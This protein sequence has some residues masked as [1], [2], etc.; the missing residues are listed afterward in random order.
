MVIRTRTNVYQTSYRLAFVTKYRTPM[1]TTETYRGTLK[2]L[3]YTAAEENEID[4]Q[5][6]EITED[7]VQLSVSFPPKYSISTVIKKL[8]GVSARR[9]FQLF[10]ETKDQLWNGHLWH[11]TY[12]A[13]TTG[14][15]STDMVLEYIEDQKSDLPIS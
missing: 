15:V 2:E 14:D 10:P 12:F 1:F 5:T 3:L 9:W 13:G 8:K 7:S 4:I 11:G 6:L